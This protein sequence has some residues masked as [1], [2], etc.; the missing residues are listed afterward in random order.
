MTYQIEIL[1]TGLNAWQD[2]ID[3]LLAF[4]VEAFRE[5]RLR[6]D[7]EKKNHIKFHRKEGKKHQPNQSSRSV[8]TGINL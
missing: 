6:E 3:Q 2:A 1:I 5:K 8:I 7:G 4:L